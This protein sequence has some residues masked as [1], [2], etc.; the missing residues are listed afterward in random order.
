MLLCVSV[1]PK[2]INNLCSQFIQVLTSALKLLLGCQAFDF[3]CIL[4]I[5]MQFISEFIWVNLRLNRLTQAKNII[6][7]T[8]QLQLPLHLPLNSHWKKKYSQHVG[9]YG[10]SRQLLN[11]SAFSGVP[12]VCLEGEPFILKPNCAVYIKPLT[13]AVFAFAN[14]FKH[15][16]PVNEILYNSSST[17]H[18]CFSCQILINTVY[19]F[20]NV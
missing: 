2:Y 15:F 20:R 4:C 8:L 6:I 17:F 16:L 12:T 14:S 7:C 1:Y 18:Q 9:M 3:Q 13:E 11:Q 10:I 19:C 5:A